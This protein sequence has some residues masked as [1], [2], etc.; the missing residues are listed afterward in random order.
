MFDSNI[1]KFKNL[2][3]NHD[4]K[5]IYNSL[6]KFILI[7]ILHAYYQT[8]FRNFII[9]SLEIVFLYMHTHLLSD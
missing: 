4:R 5:K 9:V 8:N 3:P 7:C 2:Y 6:L 1:P